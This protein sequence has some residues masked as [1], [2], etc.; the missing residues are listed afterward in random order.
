MPRKAKPW[1]RAD[2]DGWYVTHEGRQTPLGVSGPGS[3][4]EAHAAWQQL[5][6]AAQQLQQIRTPHLPAVAAVTVRAAVAGFLLDRTRQEL[7][8]GTL[9]SYRSILGQ[10]VAA[11]GDRAVTSLTA[12]EV[13]GWVRRPG[14]SS[15]SRA[16]YLAHAGCCL[17]WAG[18]PLRLRRPPVESRGADVVLTDAQFLLVLG[19]VGVGTDFAALLRVLRETGARPQEAARLTA[20]AVD[21]ANGCTRAREHKGRRLGKVRV[22]HFTTEAMRVLAGQRDRHRSGLLFRRRDGSGF[23]PM[24]IVKR[25]EGVSKRVGFR[26][27]AYGLGRH[28]FATKALTA[29][30]PA[31]H[32]AALLGHHDTKMLFHHY[33]H[34]GEQATALKASAERVSG[35]TLSD[36]AG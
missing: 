29:G 5:L 1:Y 35:A 20:E 21:W 18:H 16:S 7:G 28:S 10:L 14:L 36:G 31:A 19:A 13:E 30:V 25:M 12:A 3:E 4:P 8:A 34:L 23:H 2:R 22:L 11:F 33:A 9:Q 6:Q 27:I 32:V 15:T 24:A 26:A 17:R